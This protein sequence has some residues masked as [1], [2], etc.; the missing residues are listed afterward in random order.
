MFKF[1]SLGKTGLFVLSVLS[2]R[3][4]LYGIEII[5][6]VEKQF[7]KELSISS[8]YSC[9]TRLE[10]KEYIERSFIGEGTPDRGGKRK[11]FYKI[12]EK[13]IT[14]LNEQIDELKKASKLSLILEKYIKP[15][16]SGI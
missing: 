3:K 4:N 13:G 8:V 5:D 1:T 11:I 12:T 14:I 9:L 16:P 7:G 6:E 2:C 10:K 15:Q